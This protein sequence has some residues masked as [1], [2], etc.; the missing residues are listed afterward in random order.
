[1]YTS[2]VTSFPIHKG[3]VRY[4]KEKGYWT[5]KDDNWNEAAIKFVDEYIKAF[6]EAK[7][8]ALAKKGGVKISLKSKKWAEIW[9]K[10]SKDLKPLLMRFK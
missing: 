1:L 4:L 5:A 2:F 10:H 7:W 8:E 9:A 3:T 6:D